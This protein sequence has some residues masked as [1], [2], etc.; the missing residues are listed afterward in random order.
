MQYKVK[1]QGKTKTINI[2]EN[3]KEIQYA[4]KIINGEYL[5]DEPEILACKRFFSDLERQGTDEFPYVFDTTRGDRIF[6]FFSQCAN[7]DAVDGTFLELAEFQYYDLSQIFSWVHRDTG[8]RRFKEALIFQS[9]GQGKS[10][11]CAVIE[12][13][14][15]C[16]DKIYPPYQPEK[17]HF[18]LNPNIVSMA[19]DREQ[20]K[21][22]RKT[23]MDM[24]RR[25]PFLKDQIDVKQTY[26]KGKKRGG[27]IAAISKEIGN[28]DGAKLNL[29]VA[30]EIAAHKEES[31]INVLRGSF[32]KREQCL[33]LKITTAGDDAMIKPAKTDYD[34]CLEV[35]HGRIKDDT[36]F[37]M[38]R[39]LGEKDD[40]SDFSLYEKCAPMLRENNAYSK[41]LLEQIKD[42]FNKAF[43][44]G[45]EQQKIEYLIKRTN[46]WQVASEQKYL[47][48]EMLDMLVASQMPEKEFLQMVKGM[49]CV[50][51]IDA[52]KVID[53][54]A[55]SFV[56][57]L[58]DGKIGIYAHAFMPE[59]SLYR[60]LKTDKLPYQ[61]YAEKGLITLIDGA[62]IDN[63]ELMQ[64]LCDFER[65]NDC[66]IRLIS[67]DAA[68]AYQLLIQL[69]AGRTPNKK[70]YETVECPQT[71][72]V[73]NEPTITFQ[74]LLLDKKIVLCANELFLKHASNCYTEVDK[75]GRMKVS[76]KNT[77]SVYRIDLIAA[78][79]F[80]LRKLNV[81]DDQNLIQ[82]IISGDFSF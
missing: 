1:I 71:T 6:N 5:A 53:L 67:A 40:P 80:A 42:E 31:R 51:G 37:I 18:E 81:L 3:R 17:G 58:P 28:L 73:L 65:E 34:R 45:S 38:I 35:L 64:Y 15:L 26:I 8:T 10:T 57:K 49:P 54:T 61:S 59:D 27:E 24:A 30:D 41:R 11:E 74:K 22:V 19:V 55:E 72:A 44:G 68:Y 79:M 14:V 70:V 77:G 7:I 56:F 21:F 66:E 47:T 25:S 16:A 12:L 9:R 32:G 23:A 76:K 63:E 43:S 46:R 69:N 78:T 33:L 20:T 2:D 39:Q 60:H 62:Y 82:S 48:Q 36:Y 4:R 29:I 50:V 13:Y 75:G 52:S